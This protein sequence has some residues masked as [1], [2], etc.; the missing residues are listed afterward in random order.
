MAS[1][2]LP[3][4]SSVFSQG[5]RRPSRPI[6]LPRRLV[7]IQEASWRP[8]KWTR[9]GS[10]DWSWWWPKIGD[11]F[12]CWEWKDWGKRTTQTERG[13][14]KCCTLHSQGLESMWALRK[15]EPWKLFPATSFNAQLILSTVWVLCATAKDFFVQAHFAS[16]DRSSFPLNVPLLIFDHV[17][18]YFLDNK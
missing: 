7:S 18:C 9:R 16:S 13:W 8:E 17:V 10:W 6:S 4:T 12:L 5:H 3:L 14:S 1:I 15:P 11:G 2:I